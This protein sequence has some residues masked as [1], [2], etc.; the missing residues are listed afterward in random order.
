LYF[1]LLFFRDQQANRLLYKQK[2]WSIDLQIPH[3]KLI[4]HN[5][6]ISLVPNAR[7]ERQEVRDI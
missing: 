5:M 4:V 1:R 2:K 7:K 3:K 6:P